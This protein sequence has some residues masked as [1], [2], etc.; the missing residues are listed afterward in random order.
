MA[1]RATEND[2][3]KAAYPRQAQ[4][5]A[6][7]RY[8]SELKARYRDALPAQD[9]RRTVDESMGVSSLTE[10]LYRSREDGSA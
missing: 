2:K 7:S 4:D 5:S 10:L 1:T 6:V 8:V 3:P 9:A